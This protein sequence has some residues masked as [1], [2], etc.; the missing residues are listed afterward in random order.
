MAI[1]V[2]PYENGGRRAMEE[3]KMCSGC[4]RES[5]KKNIP[6]FGIRD[7]YEML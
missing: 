7:R 5:R 3:R 6:I 1:E 4:E 2:E